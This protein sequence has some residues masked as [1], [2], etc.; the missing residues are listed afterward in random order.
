MATGGINLASSYAKEVDERFYKE[1]QAVLALNNK[2]KFTGEK[3][4]NVYSIPTVP[5]TDY[6]RN[7]LSRYGVPSDLTRNVQSLTITRDRSFTFIIDKGD[8]LES[9]MVMDAGRALAREVR[10]VVVPE[11]DTYVFKKMAAAAT[12]RGNYSNE[13]IT[14]DNAYAAFLQGEEFLGNHNVP[15]SG[16]VAFCSYRFANYLMQDPAFI[17]YANQSQE[18]V[19]KGILGEVDG[20]KIVKVASS[21]LPA[22]TAFIITHPDA[23]TAPKRLWEYKTHSDPPGLSGWLCEG[24]YLYDAFILNEKANCIYYHGSQPVLQV[25]NVTTAATDIGKSTILIDPAEHNAN[26]T[27]WYYQT[28]ADAAS[29]DEVTYGTAI[30]TGNWTEFNGSGEEITPT[31]GDTVLAVVEVDSDSKPI[32]LGNNILNIG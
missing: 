5:M 13:E 30:T 3:T 23:T 32:A 28:A 21:R 2:Y 31:D 18:M 26:G 6:Q 27:K 24:R 10:E 20:V 14:K 15:D 22:G 7:G 4:V 19:I 9:Q 25:I 12:A 8:K 1:S 16:R 17:K 11:F 29:L